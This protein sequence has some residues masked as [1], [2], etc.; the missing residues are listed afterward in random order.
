MSSAGISNH[1]MPDAAVFFGLLIFF[2]AFDWLFFRSFD[3][4]TNG[5]ISLGQLCYIFTLFPIT[6]LTNGPCLSVAQ[7]PCS[8]SRRFTPAW[9]AVPA[10]LWR[11]SPFAWASAWRVIITLR[12]FRGL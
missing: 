2:S 9:P 11:R 1:T 3:D 6:F 5:Q 7:N 4:S 12:N 8:P 10:S